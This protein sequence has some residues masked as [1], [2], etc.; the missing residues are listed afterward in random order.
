[1]ASLV[2]VA[3]LWPAPARDPLRA[4]ALAA[5]RALAARLRAD[6]AFLLGEPTAPPTDAAQHEAAVATART[7]R[8]A[9]L[10][11]TFL[12]TPYRPT[13]LS[14]PRPHGRATGR[15]AEL[16]ERDRGAAA[17]RPRRQAAESRR[18]ARSSWPR[19]RAARARRRPARI[20][21]RPTSP[22]P[23][24][25][26]VELRRGLDEVESAT[27]DLP[28]HRATASRRAATAPPTPGRGVHHLARPELP[29]PGAELR[30]LADRRATSTW[31]P[32]PS[33]AAGWT[34]CSAASPRDC[35]HAS[36]RPRSGPAAHVERHSV[37]LHNSV[38]ARVASAWPSS[39]PTVTGVQHSFWVVSARCRCCAPTP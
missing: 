2:A 15:R 13:G 38:R 8:C 33:G 3:L 9:A 29:R 30:R 14:T 27:D 39:S 1:M 22:R 4:P 5:C 37:W 24:A 36:P 11:R 10:H 6:V 34:G 21:R 17:A 32:P 19:P 26:L 7:R 12:A 35:R 28:V 31:P 18:P 16:A 25:E 20:D 23:R